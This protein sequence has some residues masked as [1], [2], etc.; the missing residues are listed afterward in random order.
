M[1]VTGI[2]VSIYKEAVAAMFVT[3]NIHKN[4]FS[5]YFQECEISGS[6]SSEREVDS[7]LGYSAV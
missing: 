1:I 7:R 4:Y 6:Y 2:Y 5:Q 3:L